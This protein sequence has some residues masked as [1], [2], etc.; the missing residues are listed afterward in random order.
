MPRLAAHAGLVASLGLALAGCGATQEPE[1]AAYIM[2]KL[3]LR[4][5]PLTPEL[6]G[7][8]LKLALEHRCR[9]LSR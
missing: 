6:D 1:L 7:R 8:L 3:C 4:A 9:R 5:A 2:A